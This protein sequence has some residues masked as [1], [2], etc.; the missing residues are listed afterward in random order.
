M[1]DGLLVRLFFCCAFLISAR[2]EAVR[3]SVAFGLCFTGVFISTSPAAWPL[4]LLSVLWAVEIWPSS[5]EEGRASKRRY[6]EFD[7]PLASRF[8]LPAACFSAATDF[9]LALGLGATTRFP[10]SSL[11]GGA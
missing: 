7:S 2:V 9:L 6:F 3:T 8:L 1:G 10:K 5:S 11:V 4:R